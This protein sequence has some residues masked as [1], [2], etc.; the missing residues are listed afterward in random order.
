[1]EL[2]AYYRDF[3]VVSHLLIAKGCISMQ[4]QAHTFLVSF[5]LH[6]ATTVHS[7]LERKFPNHYPDDPY[8]TD[9][10]YDAA[11]YALAWQHAAPLIELP[12]EI[13]TLS[14]PARMTLA[15]LQSP[16]PTFHALPLATEAPSP[17]QSEPVAAMHALTWECATSPVLAP[18]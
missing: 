11:L 13:P 1:M 9:N 2:R 14:T 7:R 12:R 8:K 15:P 3:L 6:L 16:P 5:E 10:I 4:M 17:V 18:V